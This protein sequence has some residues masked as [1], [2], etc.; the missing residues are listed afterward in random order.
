MISMN[1]TDIANLNIKSADNCCII[2]KNKK[3]EAINL[4]QNII[5]LTRKGEHCKT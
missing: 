1:L 3:S 2:K 5:D 4:M